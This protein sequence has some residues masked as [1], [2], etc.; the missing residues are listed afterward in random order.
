M[1]I[2]PI[3]GKKKQLYSYHLLGLWRHGNRIDEMK[4]KRKKKIEKK[5]IMKEKSELK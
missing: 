1:E 5:I 3:E 2:E 4:K